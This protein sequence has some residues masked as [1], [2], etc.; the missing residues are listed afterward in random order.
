MK[1]IMR[2]VATLL[3]CGGCSSSS[4][5]GGA[6]ESADAAVAYA[7]G[8]ANEPPETTCPVAEGGTCVAGDCDLRSL[9]TGLAC[10]DGST[11]LADIDP[12]ANLEANSDTDYYACDCLGGRWVC[13]LCAPGGAE[14]A[15][16]SP[17]DAKGTD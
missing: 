14:C 15:D 8:V 2:A 9:P 13:G 3:M 4:S 5:S 1:R 12:C 10:A 16:A 11:C 6:A 17:D 7:C